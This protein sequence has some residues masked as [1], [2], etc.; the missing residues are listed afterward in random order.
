MYLFIDKLLAFILLILF[1]PLFFILFLAVK[2][3]SRG[4]FIFKQPRLGKNKKK[5]IMYKIRTM[6]MN[7]EQIKRLYFGLNEADGPV[8]KINND[9]RYTKIGRFLSHTGLDE[10]PQLINIIKGEMAFVGPRPL[11]IDEALQIPKQYE[12][13][14]SILPGITSPWVIGGSHSLSFKQWMEMDVN[15]VQNRSLGLDLKIALQTAGLI[16]TFIIKQIRIRL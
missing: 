1:L 7:A 11:P 12:M 8:F 15:Y 5:F 14:F 4:H 16:G 10:L 3:E 2:I 9:P 6:R 13:R